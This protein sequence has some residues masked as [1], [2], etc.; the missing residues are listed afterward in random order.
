MLWE[1][2]KLSDLSIETND[3]SSELAIF[4]VYITGSLLAE[5]LRGLN[6]EM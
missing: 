6:F 3:K 5:I 4:P 1:S 2:E